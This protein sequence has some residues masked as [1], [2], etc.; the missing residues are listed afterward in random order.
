MSLY[1]SIRQ[2]KRNLFNI[3]TNTTYHYK[4]LNSNIRKALKPRQL[5]VS[6]NLTYYWSMLGLF[7]Y[8]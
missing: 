4:I 8:I 2:K 7:T 1:K 3:Y 5:E 6:Y